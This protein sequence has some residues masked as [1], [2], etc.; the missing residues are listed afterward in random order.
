MTAQ[1]ALNGRNSFF[2]QSVNRVEVSG[3]QQMN[4]LALYKRGRRWVDSRVAKSAESPQ[5]EIQFGSEEFFELVRSLAKEGRQGVVALQGDIL[6]Q[7]NG[8]TVLVRGPD[9]AHQ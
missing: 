1:K 3:V 7:V 6:L 5:R 4:D 9:S 2:D 8:E